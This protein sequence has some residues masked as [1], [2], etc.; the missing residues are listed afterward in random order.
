MTV[1]HLPLLCAIERV[2]SKLLFLLI[3]GQACGIDESV[4]DQRTGISLPSIA[5][6]PE[7]L[8]TSVG[9]LLQEVFLVGIDATMVDTT[10]V[11]MLG[12]NAQGERCQKR[13]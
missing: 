13:A 11:N 4:A 9:P 10:E 1:G 8:G 12:R 2:A 3:V 5:H 7:L 6:H